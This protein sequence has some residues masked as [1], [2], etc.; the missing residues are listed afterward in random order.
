[1]AK[2]EHLR[3]YLKTAVEIDEDK[4]ILIDQYICGKEVRRH[5]FRIVVDYDCLISGLFDRL[6]RMYRGIIKLH[7]L[8]DTDWTGTKKTRRG[9]RIFG[10]ADCN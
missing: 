7:T 8:T 6:N 2:E 5:G 9:Y 10:R 1:M 4:P 3:H